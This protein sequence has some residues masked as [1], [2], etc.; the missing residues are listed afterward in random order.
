MIPFEQIDSRAIRVT[1][2]SQYIDEK[3]PGEFAVDHVIDG[4]L[5][6]TAAECSCC[7]TVNENGWIQLDLQ[8]P[9]LLDHIVIKGRSDRK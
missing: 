3:K 1:A 5:N 7:G 4:I 2:K 9:Y 8:R 6:A